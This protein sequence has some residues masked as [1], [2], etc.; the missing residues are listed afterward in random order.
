MNSK[1]IRTALLFF[2][3]LVLPVVAVVRVLDRFPMLS[4]A[5]YLVCISSATFFLY[6]LDKRKAQSQKWRFRETTLHLLEFFGGLAAAFWA[7]RLLRHKNRKT[8]YQIVFWMIAFLHQF[9]AYDYLN[10]WKRIGWLGDIIEAL[11]RL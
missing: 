5:G 9:I 3:Y 11:F 2:A 6:W 8:Y 10:G 4:V 7:Q 1:N